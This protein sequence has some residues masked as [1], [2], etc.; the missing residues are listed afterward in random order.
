MQLSATSAAQRISSASQAQL[1]SAQRNLVHFMHL[2]ELSAVQRAQRTSQLSAAQ[3]DSAHVAQLS[4]AQFYRSSSAVLAQLS[5]TQRN[6][7]AVQ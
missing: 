2:N 1:S 5:A 3:R 6:L 4:S 7:N